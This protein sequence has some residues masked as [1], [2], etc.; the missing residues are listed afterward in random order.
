MTGFLILNHIKAAVVVLA[1]MNAIARESA[2]IS[3]TERAAHTKTMNA[4]S[5]KKDALPVKTATRLV[6]EKSRDD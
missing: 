6:M 2:V 3:A 1:E 5:M 4:H